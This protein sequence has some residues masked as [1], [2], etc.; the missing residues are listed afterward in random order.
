MTHNKMQIENIDFF[1]GVQS[2]C[3]CEDRGWHNKHSAH[4]T[5]SNMGGV[6]HTYMLVLSN[7][8]CCDKVYESVFCTP[9]RT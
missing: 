6:R 3:L 2:I 5:G 8:L 9:T 1:E 7:P 4:Y